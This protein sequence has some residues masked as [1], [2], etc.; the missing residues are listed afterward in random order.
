LVNNRIAPILSHLFYPAGKP[1][2]ARSG[3]VKGLPSIDDSGTLDAL[4]LK[5]SGFGNVG[6]NHPPSSNPSPS[7]LISPLPVKE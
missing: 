6:V 3:V 1:E 7:M 2:D 5:P 4:A